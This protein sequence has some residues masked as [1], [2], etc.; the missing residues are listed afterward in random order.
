[1]QRLQALLFS[2]KISYPFSEK[3]KIMKNNKDDASFRDPAGFVFYDQGQVYRYI[4]RKYAEEYEQLMN[5]GLFNTLVQKGFILDHKEISADDVKVTDSYKIIKPE[6][7]D[8]V[9]YPYE[10][11]FSQ[12]KAAA[13]LTLDILE[14][15]LQY[16]M[17]LKDASAYN[18]QLQKG[19]LVLIDTLSFE[20][21]N[22][23]LPWRAY[24][25]FV[26]HFLGP[27]ALM[28]YQ[29]PR[30]ASLMKNHIDGIPLD[31]TCKLLP[32]RSFLNFGLVLH[33][34]THNAAQNKYDDKKSYNI[35]DV[36]FS[37]KKMHALIQSLRDTISSL[38]YDA[39][40]TEWAEYESSEIHRNDYKEKKETL[41]QEYVAEADP[42]IIIDFGAN[43]GRY[44]RLMMTDT[45][46]VI[47][48][49]IDVACVDKNYINMSV[50]HERNIAPVVFDILNPNP[51][52][53]WAGRE[54]K[55]LRERVDPDLVVALAIVH[56]LRISGGIPLMKIAAM[57]FEY[58][59]W[60]VIEFVP[61]SDDLVGLLLKNRE[62]LFDDYNRDNFIRI[63]GDYFEIMKNAVL[64]ESGREIFLM[65]RI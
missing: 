19:R 37:I 29:D 42:H 15:A 33:V 4:S 60:L 36:G 52:I 11:S 2:L 53:G 40:G 39:K 45:R 28:S 8:F 49:D 20:K 22:P 16:G 9:S 62:D 54:R 64:S 17:V 5:S 59:E 35:S 25:Q 43:V 21:Y 48:C 61:K 10:W 26:R 32:I 7:L 18:V 1:L 14:I 63:F 34:Y 3:S 46:L 27:L 65:R 30:L 23:A 13:V 6:K 56:H 51:S 55:S 38:K 31:L 50:V 41:L 58:S 24:G 47:S 12:Y 44:S 57:F